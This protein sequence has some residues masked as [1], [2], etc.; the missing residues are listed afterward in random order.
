MANKKFEITRSRARVAFNLDCA[1][2]MRSHHSQENPFVCHSSAMDFLTNH[3]G[4]CQCDGELKTCD[5]GVSSPQGDEC[6][7]ESA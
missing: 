2:Q 6:D 7:I 3:A 1:E 5:D 4:A